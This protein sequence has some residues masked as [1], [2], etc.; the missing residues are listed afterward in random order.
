MVDFFILEV[1]FHPFTIF[2]LE[3]F[4]FQLCL[5]FFFESPNFLESFVVV[6]FVLIKVYGVIIGKVYDIVM[7]HN[8]KLVPTQSQAS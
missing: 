1:K 7:D 2:V 8:L 6:W 3:W 5:G 4:F